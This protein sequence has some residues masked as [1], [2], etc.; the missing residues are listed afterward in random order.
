MEFNLP[1]WTDS[2][3]TPIT[4]EKLN[5][6][7]DAIRHLLDNRS[8]VGDIVCSTN[9]DTEEK[10][11]QRFG[12]ITWEK[13]EG[14]FLLGSGIP[15]DNT[16]SN[17]GNNLTYNGTDKYDE[18]VGNMGGS[19]LHTLTVAE[20]PSHNHGFIGEYGATGN[21]SY[22][23]TDS[24]WYIQAA[25]TSAGARQAVGSVIVSTGGGGSHN[26]MPPYFVIHIWK[27][28]A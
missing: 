10:V 20:M 23:P 21:K 25:G 22:P 15:K 2:P 24:G 3:E 16:N 8:Q 17:F 1:I 12:G 27:R 28:T 6:M 26:N 4:A 19:S 5:V 13:I 14:R 9:L 7:V 18:P 11:I